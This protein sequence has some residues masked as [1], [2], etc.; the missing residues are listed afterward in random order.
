MKTSHLLIGG[1]VVYVLFIKPKEA[2]ASTG[3]GQLPAGQTGS[4]GSW[5]DVAR[6]ILGLGI[7]VVDAVNRN[8]DPQPQA[9]P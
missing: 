1:L 5:V 8:K 4:T 2:Q 7:K 6:D 3:G 9:N